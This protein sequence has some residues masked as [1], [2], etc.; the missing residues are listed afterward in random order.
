MVTTA[1]SLLE[2]LFVYED[3]SDCQR[4]GVEG[5]K[6]WVEPKGINLHNMTIFMDDKNRLET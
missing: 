3:I 5:Q 6:E 4:E 1:G 2:R